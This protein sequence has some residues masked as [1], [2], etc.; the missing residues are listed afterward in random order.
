MPTTTVRLNKPLLKEGLYGEAVEEL[1]KLLFDYG[2]Y[3]LAGF[4]NIAEN[5]LVDGFFGA[6]TTAALK[7]FQR[8]M[9]LQVDGLAGEITWQALYKG[10]PI[11]MPTLKKGDRG[12][13]VKLVQERLQLLNIQLKID[14]EFGIKTEDAVKLLQKNTGLPVTGIIENRTWIELGKLVET[15]GC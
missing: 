7:A 3:G 5:D 12:N 6:Q 14:G 10:S 15:I 1:Q 9:F 2:A 13:L 8:Q 11:G 4:F